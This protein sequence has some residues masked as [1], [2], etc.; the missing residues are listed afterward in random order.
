[1]GTGGIIKLSR[2]TFSGRLHAVRECLL[3][4]L[5]LRTRHRVVNTSMTPTATAGDY[6]L[7]NPT[8]YRTSRP[9]PGDVVLARHPLDSTLTITK[10]IASVS[11]STVELVSD[12]PDCGQDSRHFGPLPIALL[13]GQVTC[14][15][16]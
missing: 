7:V 1:M 9:V 16:R 12:N 3:W 8:A 13:R 5:Q 15:I 2:Y 14:I 6:L 10:R 4:V 11:E